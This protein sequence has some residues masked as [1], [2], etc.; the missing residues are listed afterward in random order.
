MLLDQNHI[1]LK[2]NSESN[3]SILK[4]IICYPHYTDEIFFE[5]IAEL[6]SLKIDYFEL[7]GPTIIDGFHLLGKGTRGLVVKAHSGNSFFALKIRRTDSPRYDL[8]NEAKIQKIV[9]QF[10]IA[11]KI[12][13]S[14]LLYTSPSPRD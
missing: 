14:C 9:N 12:F 11:P 13:N 10:N 4:K 8:I 1:Y 2:I 5:R 7:E 6:Q 3:S